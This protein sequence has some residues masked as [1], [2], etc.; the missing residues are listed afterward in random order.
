M[1]PL[2]IIEDNTAQRELIEKVIRDYIIIREMD[3]SI[4]L[5]T[6]NPYE[7][8]G[9]LSKNPHLKGIYFIDID[10]KMDMDGIELGRRI[11][12]LDPNGRIVIVT[13]K[14]TM[15]RLTFVHKLEALDY[16]VKESAAEV[17]SKIEKCVKI[18]YDRWQQM[19]VEERRVL[20]L[21]VGKR[22]RSVPMEEVC[23]I[24]TSETAH[25]LI[26]HTINGKVEFRGNIRDFEFSYPNLTRVHRSFLANLDNIEEIDEEQRRL[27]AVNGNYCYL[28]TRKLSFV[29]K[30]LE[31]R[32]EIEW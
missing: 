8:L 18:A 11:K 21:R 10:L 32:K 4:V 7:C 12:E 25:R 16:I 1:L 19:S 26:L 28:S 2:F 30:E 9:Y 14:E 22:L 23:Y 5:T 20:E 13:A 31:K 24:E 6:A 29:R 17:I 3:V 27:R 15:A